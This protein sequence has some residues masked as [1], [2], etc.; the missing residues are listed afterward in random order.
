MN[1]FQDPTSGLLQ[2]AEQAGMRERFQAL[3]LGQ[4][5]API[6]ERMI[7][8]GVKNASPSIIVSPKLDNFLSSTV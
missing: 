5:Q 2:L 1:F 6:A 8:N 4:G 3:S 7:K